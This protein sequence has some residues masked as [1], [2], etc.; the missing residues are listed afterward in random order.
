[1]PSIILK[2][3]FKLK[4]NQYNADKTFSFH[5]RVGRDLIDSIN[6]RLATFRLTGSANRLHFK[7]DK[8]GHFFAAMNH[9]CQKY[10]EEDIVV[11]ILDE[12]E[13]NGFQFRFQ[14]D[15]ETVSRKPGG[16]SRTSKEL[17][18]FHR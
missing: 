8:E 6:R 2:K 3:T 14:Y 11:L 17:F 18:M 16:G 5:G 12:M 10:H 15:V 7:V 4:A 9:D 1:M 13:E